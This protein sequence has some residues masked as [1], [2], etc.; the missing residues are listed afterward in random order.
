MSGV[1]VKIKKMPTTL[2]TVRQAAV[3][4]T[5]P[6]ELYLLPFG[7][8]V[9]YVPQGA[10]LS[11]PKRCNEIS[12]GEVLGEL[13]ATRAPEKWIQYCHPDTLCRIRGEGGSNCVYTTFSVEGAPSENRFLRFIS[14]TVAEK[15]FS[16]IRE[17]LEDEIDAVANERQA[18]RFEVLNWKKSVDCPNRTQL[19]PELEKWTVV[20]G[21]DV[22]KSVAR[23]PE[24]KKR[25]KPGHA[26][27]NETELMIGEHIATQRFFKKPQNTTTRVIET[28]SLVHVI[29]YKNSEEEDDL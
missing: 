17:D 15:N 11:F 23:A 4:K 16:K 26:A 27:N 14:A 13:I 12:S 29:F 20:T 25:Q 10:F 2:T 8:G 21:T 19:S 6:P 9:Y 1:V 5:N 24:T 22:V 7:K 28:D 18:L 3:P